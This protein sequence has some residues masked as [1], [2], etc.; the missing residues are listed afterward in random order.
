MG[1]DPIY[2]GYMQV[3]LMSSDVHDDKNKH[4]WQ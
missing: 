3:K 1:M 4:T 2:Q